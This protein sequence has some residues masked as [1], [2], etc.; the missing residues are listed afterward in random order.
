VAAIEHGLGVV[1]L[2]RI[3]PQAA[4]DMPAGGHEGTGIVRGAPKSMVGLE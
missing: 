4:L 3:E 1:L 2:G